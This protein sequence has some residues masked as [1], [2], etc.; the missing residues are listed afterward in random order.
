V[1]NIVEVDFGGK[2]FRKRVHRHT[3][4]E[5]TRLDYDENIG[6]IA[7][8]LGE[9]ATMLGRKKPVM[10]FVSTADPENDHPDGSIH[11]LRGDPKAPVVVV[12]E[13]VTDFF[14]RNGQEDPKQ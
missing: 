13:N 2:R 5:Q 3:L 7:T 1:D 9:K 12:S 4:V 14:R 10:D 8:I 11:V 6:I